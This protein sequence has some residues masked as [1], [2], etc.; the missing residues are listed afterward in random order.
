MHLFRKEL[1]LALGMI[2]NFWNS[3]EFFCILFDFRRFCF[4]FLI[5]SQTN[6]HKKNTFSRELNRISL[7]LKQ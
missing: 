3:F 5:E 4:C 2:Q 1:E 7:A 6:L